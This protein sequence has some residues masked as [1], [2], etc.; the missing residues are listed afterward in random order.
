MDKLFSLLFIFL[1]ILLWRKSTSSGAVAAAIGLVVFLALC[2]LIAYFVFDTLT[3]SG[4]DA[5]IV[6]HLTTG[7][8]GAPTG[9]FTLLGL[10]AGTMLVITVVLSVYSY[11]SAKT[12][13]ST[14]PRWVRSLLALG[15]TSASVYLNPA[16]S[17]IANRC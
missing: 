14:H 2:L 4:I 15:F 1:A 8:E 6:Y 5:S 11:R 12:K 10:A 3:G 7:L 9:D 13:V 16:S 17:D